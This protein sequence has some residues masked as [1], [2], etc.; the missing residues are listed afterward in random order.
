MNNTY[1]Y[2]NYVIRPLQTKTFS[3][4]IELTLNVTF[5]QISVE[6]FSVK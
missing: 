1:K 2:N 3:S 5:K 6:L 4:P